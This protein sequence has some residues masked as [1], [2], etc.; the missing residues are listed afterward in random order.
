ME[1]PSIKEA[2]ILINEAFEMFPGVWAEHNRVAGKCAR[3]IAEPIP[4]RI[5]K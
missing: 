4:F 5:K 1:I 2:E 3:T